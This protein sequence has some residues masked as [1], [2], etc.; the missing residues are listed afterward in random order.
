MDISDSNS[1]LDAFKAPWNDGRGDDVP[2]TVFHSAANIRFWE[3]VKALLHLSNFVN[4]RGTQNIIDGCHNIGADILIYTSSASIT[5]RSNQF[6]MLPWKK[7]PERFIQILDDDT[8]IPTEHE[9][10]FSNYAASKAYAER[11]VREADKSPIPRGRLLRTG[12]I[13]PG[14][15]IYGPG[16]DILAGAYLVRK[17]NHT[18]V[19][20]IVQSFVYVENC[21]L[22]HL[23][24]EQRI[25]EFAQYGSSATA[26]I[27]GQAFNITDPN[28]PVAFGD[29][30]TTLTTLTETK[31]IDL[32]PVL[33]L[34]IAYLIEKYYLAR[35][36]SPFWSYI[37]PKPNSDLA[38]LQPS[39]FNLIQVHLI[40][41]D[42]RARKAP[43]E[44]GLGYDPPWTTMEGLC[45]LVIE[46]QKEGKREEERYVMGGQSSFAAGVETGWVQK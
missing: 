44:G 43:K 31:F 27:S 16:G 21:A 42:S 22:A 7:F 23:L 3:R 15:G 18:W 33:M 14:N 9:L 26:D 46:W 40:F 4:V 41:D 17:I 2:I 35:M 25:L 36:F 39:L 6:W 32:P 10:F 24:Y 38:F 45:K 34:S 28:P 37:L 1:V 8:P 13:R 12:C 29:V 19:R 20:N 11:L 5:T 30:Y